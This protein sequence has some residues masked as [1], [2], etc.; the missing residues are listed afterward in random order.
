[1]AATTFTGTAEQFATEFPQALKK[2]SVLAGAGGDPFT[3]QSAFITDLVRICS[4]I[5]PGNAVKAR[6]ARPGEKYYACETNA[7][8][9]PINPQ[10]PEILCLVSVSGDY[11]KGKGFSLRV[12]LKNQKTGMMQIVIDANISGPS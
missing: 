3:E 7:P 6:R 11:S 12:L 2:A 10:H 8:R 1:M 4:Q 9:V 5:N